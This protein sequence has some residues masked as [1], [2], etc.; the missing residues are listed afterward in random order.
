MRRRRAGSTQLRVD[1]ACCFAELAGRESSKTAW[2]QLPLKKRRGT[3]Q[4]TRPQRM[5]G[6]VPENGQLGGRAQ[7]AGDAA[8]RGQYPIQLSP[9]R[10]PPPFYKIP[11]VQHLKQR[12]PVAEA[13]VELFADRQRSLCAIEVPRQEREMT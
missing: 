9:A 6:A 5:I 3:G 10:A 13:R 7:F 12:I 1:Q 11:I 2:R 4:V 8:S